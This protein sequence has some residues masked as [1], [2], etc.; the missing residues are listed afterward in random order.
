MR[1]AASGDHEEFCRLELENRKVL[2]YPPFGRLVKILLSGK[3][4]EA[5]EK[6]AGR[7]GELLRQ[8]SSPARR[9]EG[10]G[11]LSELKKTGAGALAS[12]PRILGQAPAPLNKLQGKFRIQILIKSPTSAVNQRLLE[13]VEDQLKPRRGV[14]LFIDVDPQSM[15]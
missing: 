7:I 4:E 13:R 6:E 12:R 1:F 2:G 3:N 14:D 10:S 11:S 5:V 9:Q 8:A 15:L